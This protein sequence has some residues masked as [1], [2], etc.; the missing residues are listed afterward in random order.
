ML[1]IGNFKNTLF[2]HKEEETDTDSLI[3]IPRLS[4]YLK[5][6]AATLVIFGT[7]F[8]IGW[9]FSDMC[10]CVVPTQVNFAIN[11]V[12]QNDPCK[13][14]ICYVYL[15]L[16]EN[17]SNSMIVMFHSGVNLKKPSVKLSLKT[18]NTSIDSSLSID[19]KD[20][21]TYQAN[22]TRLAS[23]SIERYVYV[24]YL[25]NLN[26]ETDYYFI[27]YDEEAKLYTKE[28]KFRTLPLSESLA[29]NKTIRFSVGGDAGLTSR[30]KRVLR[31][32]VLTEPYFMMIGGDITYANGMKYCYERVDK[33]F[34]MWQK[35]SIT[36]N[37][38]MVPLLTSIG[39]HEAGISFHSDIAYTAFYKYYFVHS[40]PTEN[41]IDLP[42]YHVHNISGSVIL[43][44]DSCVLVPSDHIQPDFIN[45]HLSKNYLWK[46][47][48][49]HAPLY[50]SV[51]SFTNSI[52]KSLR[53]DWEP[54][55]DRHH[56]HVGFEN[57]DH[58]YKR[59]H[60]MKAGEQ[61]TPQNGTLYLGDGSIGVDPRTPITSRDYL[62]V[63]KKTNFHF[64][65]SMSNESMIINAIDINNV[66]IDSILLNQDSS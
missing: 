56:L 39:N 10:I 35:I 9:I 29:S 62:V 17:P 26:P 58:A 66:T 65:V 57:H 15:T 55:F 34:F 7:V 31:N 36:P 30:S 3:K 42:T 19:V 43:V 47:A 44:L 12:S 8:L 24:A 11:R 53:Q 28:Y 60:F 18:M 5:L 52:S 50:P 20:A 38:Y 21:Q 33:W 51:R 54:L 40:V 45:R 14:T 32:A 1:S 16:P 46:M 25:S 37:N 63:S 4:E 13:Y 64:D 27:A 2:T 49:Y 48:L 41:L 6:A 59:T 61:V 23:L 22:K